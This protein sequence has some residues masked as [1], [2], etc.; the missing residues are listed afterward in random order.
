MG[1]G[2]AADPFPN[3]TQIRDPL[4]Q[5]VWRGLRIASVLAALG[6][7]ALLI[8]APE[9]GLDLWWELLVPLLPLVWFVAPGLWRNVCPLAATNQIPRVLGFTRGRTAPAWFRTYAP[10]AGI[11]IFFAAV[12]ARPTVFEDDGVAT[13]ALIGGALVIA[14]AG[15]FILK[16]KSGWCSSLCP[17]LPVQRMYGQTPFADLPNSHCRPCLGC[18]KNCF[19]FNP[20]VAYLADLHDGDR[21]WSTTRK[22]FT[23]AFP[24]LVIA[25]FTE[26]ETA[27]MALAVGAGAGSF[28]ALEALLPAST[29]KLAA[30]YAATAINLFYWWAAPGPD[31]VAWP[32]RAAVLALSVVWLWRTFVKERVFLER[33]GLP[34]PP[35]AARLGRGM[36]AALQRTAEI[37]VTF[38]EG[39]RIVARPGTPLLELAET[40]EQPIEAG[41]RMGVCGADPVQ[42]VSGME[43]LSPV[44]SDEQATLER[45]GLDPAHNRMACCARVQ[46]PVAVSMTPRRDSNVVVSIDFPYDPEVER[47][48]V[49]G[50]GIAGVTA[51]DHV[52]RRHPD[53]TVDVV[54][55]EP[56]PLY[57]RM[58]ISRL[59]Y[60]RSA[61]V[62]LHLL[63]DAWY[64][65]NRITCWL[66]TRAQ[67]ID[68]EASEVLL[69]TGERLRYDRLILATGS[70]A[71][72]PQIPGF[73]RPGTF[74][75]RTASDAL[76]IREYVQ[77][78]GAEHALVAG[79]GLLGLEAAYAMHKLGLRTTV[80]ERGRWLLR[81]QLDE[82]AG[83]LLRGYLANIGI[84]VL[85]ETETAALED[86]H[87]VTTDGSRVR[88]DVFLVAAGIAPAVEL[89][90]RAG[91][92]TARGV[93][94]DDHLR[95]SDGRIYAA[96]DS[97]EWRDEILGLWPVAVEQAEVAAENAVGGDR[98]Y[99]GTVPQTMLKV[100]GVE[101][102]SIG[103]ITGPNERVDEDA[104]S[105]RY[106]KLV[107]D[108]DGRVVGAILLGHPE[109]V[110]TVTAAVRRS[111]PLA[112]V[113]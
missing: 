108:E 95:T 47:I 103:A 112:E 18:T 5:S 105:L 45:L 43:S 21:Q 107:A 52:R 46:G 94:V 49:I 32:L 2:R 12:F 25:F 4:P 28:L 73:G 82:R 35:R 24:A 113:A 36:R 67:A 54:A 87:A 15:G 23:A 3:F 80:L 71:H 70:E 27:V 97:A 66:N 44:G 33:Q 60:G 41:C 89:A 16:G 92:A 55:A 50:N 76:G 74:A 1:A 17:M 39:P 72:V 91:L 19:D 6:V 38:E 29:P 96:G 68:R 111:L 22:L 56:H 109:Q 84:E 65:D 93:L 20:K 98:A 31:W 77:E 48:V 79:G 62:G 40:A 57:N 10:L 78:A 13:A 85:L 59:I 26:Q 104:E 64:D 81:R 7:C 83:E 42:I 53:C 51:A 8:A 110:P 86:G 75:L 9:T 88:A 101:L 102:L 99:A 11:A 106:R 90:R 69:G 63:P 30:L 14:F 58:G 100:V 61:M 34:T 37:E